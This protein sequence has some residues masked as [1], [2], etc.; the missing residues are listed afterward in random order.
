MTTDR[1]VFKKGRLAIEVD[2]IINE[3][4]SSGLMQ[5]NLDNEQDGLLYVPKDYKK[6][7]PCAFALMLHGAGGNPDHGMSLLRDYSDTN[8]IILLAPS[9]RLASWDII[10][11]D[12]FGADVI[13]INQA[14]SQTF[15]RYS[16][17]AKRVAIGGFSDGASY[18]LCLGLTNGDMFT[19][20]IAF[21]P[22]FAY[23]EAVV[24]KPK[25]FIS[26]GVKDHIL[27]IDPC[28]RKLVP[29]LKK[30]GYD[31][32]YK[33]FDGEH[34]IPPKISAPAVDWFKN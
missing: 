7:R 29:R 23:A 24:G 20:I 18:A 33:E 28:S 26:H 2:S 19:H 27:P 15:K 17:D 12:K 22:G 5:L 8:N 32:L 25:I 14:I 16:I 10:S 6:E 1:N 9:S 34:T 3:D 11:T 4:H 31:I 30:Q 13:F 21:S